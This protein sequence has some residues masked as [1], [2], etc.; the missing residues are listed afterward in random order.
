M[1][2]SDPTPHV[3]GRALTLALILVATALMPFPA[4]S[5]D[6]LAALLAGTPVTPDLSGLQISLMEDGQASESYALG[7]AQLGTNGDS[8]PL[9]TAHKIRVASISKLVV[10]LGVMT[11]VEDGLLDLDE[12]VSTYLGWTLHNPAFPNVPITARQLL[13]HTSSIRDASAYFIEA[14][15]GELR[16]F[17]TPGSPYWEDGGH[18]ASGEGRE[19]GRYFV[20]A[21]LNFG[22]LGT[23]IEILGEQ[24]FDLFM[25][26]RVLKPL[27]LSASFDPCAI[28]KELRAAAFRKR[29]DDEIWNPSG[30]WVAQVDGETVRCFYGMRDD[31]QA[32][33]FLATYELGSNAALYSPQGGLRASAE[34]LIVILRLLAGG[35]SLGDTRILS[36]ESVA[37]MLAP[38]WTLN[39]SGDNGLSAGEADPGGPTE[40]LMTSYGLSVHRIDTRAWGYENGPALLLGHLGEA[41]GVLS[42]ALYDPVTGDG[43]ATIIT[44]TGDDPG[45]HPGHSPLY[46]IEEEILRWWLER[47]GAA[48]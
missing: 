6:A 10:A 25:A 3:I 45:K 5:D 33:A 11:L 43:I 29:G 22:L 44:G 47:Q 28:Q 23:L 13:S 32:E 14:G 40:G 19:P 34:D 21:N 27:G 12:D 37:A 26:D 48:R 2:A 30:P 8:T 42:H 24:R 41:Y 4:H 18:F 15:A 46:R 7:F 9:N 39:D 38:D 16:D 35:G 20:Y 17:F 1:I 36:E 31:A